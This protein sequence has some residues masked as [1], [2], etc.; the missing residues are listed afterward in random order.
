MSTSV[1]DG[2]NGV[3]T[4]LPCPPAPP[5]RDVLGRLAG[6]GLA[7]A[8]I[9]GVYLATGLGLPCVFRSLTGWDCPLCG[10]TRAGAALLTGD[11]AAA[12]HANPLLLVVATAIGLRAVGWVVELVRDPRATSSPRWVPWGV[13][14]HWGWIVGAVGVAYVL[15]RNLL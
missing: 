4:T 7:A 5:A 14:R 2:H 9:S 6:L 8:A 12:W 1:G 11:L 10:G 15:A 3:V 13:A